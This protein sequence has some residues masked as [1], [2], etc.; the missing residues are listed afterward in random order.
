MIFTYRR[1][2]ENRKTI[3]KICTTANL[4]DANDFQSILDEVAKE[5]GSQNNVIDWVGK[6]IDEKIKK[7][8]SIS[9]AA[10]KLGNFMEKFSYMTH[11]GV[12]YNPLFGEENH[13][14]GGHVRRFR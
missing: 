8:D 7:T 10:S 3:E 9:Q 12:V 1:N 13:W 14:V 5:C 4:P 2:N 6:F 11:V